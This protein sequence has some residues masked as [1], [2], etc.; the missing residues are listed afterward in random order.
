MI[1]G[2]GVARR[3]ACRTDDEA[4]WSG[5]DEIEGI[6]GNQGQRPGGGRVEDRDVLGADHPRSLDAI[7]LFDLGGLGSMPVDQTAVLGKTKFVNSSTVSRL[8]AFGELRAGRV[9][10]EY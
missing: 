6:A 5:T 7:D 10:A 2:H 3:V 9:R 1:R 8:P 4:L